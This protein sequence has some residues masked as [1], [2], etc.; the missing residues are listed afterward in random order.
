VDHLLNVETTIILD[1]QSSFPRLIV[2]PQ[3]LAVE[4]H[5]FDLQIVNHQRR[6]KM[7]P[8]LRTRGG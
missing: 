4:W 8:S 2:G 1:L 5:V 6:E 7:H 3:S